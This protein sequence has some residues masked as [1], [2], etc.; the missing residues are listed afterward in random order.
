MRNIIRRLAK[1]LNLKTQ[2]IVD[3]CK[4]YMYKFSM[5]NVTNTLNIVVF[6]R[7]ISISII[8]STII[9]NLIIIIIINIILF[10]IVLVYCVNVIF[11]L[12]RL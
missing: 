5:S 8:I 6:I 12:R 2:S 4:N 11:F 9:I 10:I 1:V 7:G 3:C